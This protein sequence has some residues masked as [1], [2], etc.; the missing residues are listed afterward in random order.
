MMEVKHGWQRQRSFDGDDLF[1]SGQ[2]IRREAFLVDRSDMSQEDSSRAIDNQC[3]RDAI[4]SPVDRASSRGVDSDRRERIAVSLQRLERGSTT[5][6]SLVYGYPQPT[7]KDG[8]SKPLQPSRDW[9]DALA[10]WCSAF[11]QLD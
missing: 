11:T 9:S 4:E 10:S 2:D 8:S 7:A 5:K 3:F 1:Q 6:R